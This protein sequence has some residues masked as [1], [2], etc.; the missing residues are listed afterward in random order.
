M[1]VET[2]PSRIGLVADGHNP[3]HS[4]MA[5][6]G[7]TMKPNSGRYTIP[8]ALMAATL[9]TAV[10]SQAQKPTNSKT[11]MSAITVVDAGGRTVGRLDSN[12]VF[13]LAGT[14][15]LWLEL[16]QAPGADPTKLAWANA[17]LL[18]SNASCTGTPYV[19]PPGAQLGGYPTRTVTLP[20]GQSWLYVVSGTPV[21][22]TIAATYIGGT[23]SASPSPGNAFAVPLGTPIDLSA[24][25]TLPLT[26]Q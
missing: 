10:F 6:E 24:Q 22:V 2:R 8:I 4:F 26:L 12:R 17:L 16:D 20:S 19:F 14:V 5:E 15:P 7:V 25:F 18:F 21:S 1:T 23:C 11:A 3:Y 9:S 13:A